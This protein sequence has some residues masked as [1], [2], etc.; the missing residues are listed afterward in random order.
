VAATKKRLAK[1]L[2]SMSSGGQADCNTSKAAGES[3]R[4]VF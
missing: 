4:K 1:E 2:A 3:P